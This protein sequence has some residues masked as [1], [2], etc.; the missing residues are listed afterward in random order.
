MLAA[1]T[2]VTVALEAVKTPAEVTLKIG[3]PE[4]PIDIPS[5]PIHMPAVV[6]FKPV[7]PLYIPVLIFQLPIVDPL[8]A[9]SVPLII[10][11]VAVNPVLV[12]LKLLPA[13]PLLFKTTL[14][15]KLIELF[16]LVK[17]R[18]ELFSE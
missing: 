10:A 12:K 7:L 5:V 3:A 13:K 14:F 4:A 9:V 11:L 2:P 17:T 1:I 15:P 18:P 6:E 8:P 16:E